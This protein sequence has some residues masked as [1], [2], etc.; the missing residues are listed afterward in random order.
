M[1]CE[2]GLSKAFIEG[3]NFRLDQTDRINKGQIKYGYNY[4]NSIKHKRKK[5]KMMVTRIFFLSLQV[6]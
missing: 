1:P 6:F 3:Q 2:N 4:E 5:K